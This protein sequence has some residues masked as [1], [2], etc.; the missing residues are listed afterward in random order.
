MNFLKFCSLLTILAG[1]ATL[2]AQN[3]APE[4]APV[5]ATTVGTG[6]DYSRGSY[7]FATDT[8][9][10][11]VPLNLGFDNGPWSTNLNFSYLTLKGPATVVAGSGAARP[12]SSSQSGFGDIYA[13]VTYHFG[14]AF[15]AVNLDATA[16]VKLATANESRGLGTGQTDYYGELTVSRTLGT[17]TPFATAGYRVLGDSAV[18]QLRDG[19]YL[20]GGAHFRVSPTNVITAVLDWRQPITVGAKHEVDATAMFTHDFDANWRIAAY[21]LKGFTDASPDLGTGVQLSHRF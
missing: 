12:T 2:A 9:I 21:V 13:G 1:A 10:F 7:G 11:S 15:G 4:S 5:A 16:R 19:A 8:E 14:P 18:Y 17:T 20:S 6:F 3:T